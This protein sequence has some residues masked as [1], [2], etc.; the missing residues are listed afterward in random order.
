M[1]YSLLPTYVDVKVVP[2]AAMSDAVGGCLGPK[3][4]QLITMHSYDLK[5]K[6]V[7]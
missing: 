5:T 1:F 2:T 7:Q 4:E 3:Q 6:V